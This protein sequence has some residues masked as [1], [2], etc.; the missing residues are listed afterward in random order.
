MKG[1]SLL[2]FSSPPFHFTECLV[3]VCCTQIIGSLNIILQEEAVQKN[4]NYSSFTSV[5][6]PE[7][8]NESDPG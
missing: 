4:Y 7:N 8:D 6:E 2:P 5:S 3:I 1:N